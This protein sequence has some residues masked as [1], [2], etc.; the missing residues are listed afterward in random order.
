MRS[1]SPAC[2]AGGSYAL[3]LLVRARCSCSGSPSCPGGARPRQ[4]SRM[5]EPKVWELPLHWGLATAGS[6]FVAQQ[7]RLPSKQLASCQAANPAHTQLPLP[8]SLALAHWLSFCA[9]VIQLF[10]SLLL[11]RISPRNEP[12]CLKA[13]AQGTAA[14]RCA[15]FTY[16]CSGIKSP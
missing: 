1:T 16:S 15:T 13:L 3:Q 11:E 2:R 9:E 12:I 8:Q 10:C 4:H 5:E 14:D 7:P 6:S